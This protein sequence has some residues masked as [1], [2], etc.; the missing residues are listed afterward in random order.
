MEYIVSSGYLEGWKYKFKA[1]FF[2]SEFVASYGIT[3]NFG[4]DGRPQNMPQTGNFL[5]FSNELDT[6][7]GN[8]E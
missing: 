4:E 5:H 6:K 7:N 1:K 3:Y 2:F 8:Q